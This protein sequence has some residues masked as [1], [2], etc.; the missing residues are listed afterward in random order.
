MEIFEI[1]MDWI[2]FKL[3]LRQERKRRRLRPRHVAV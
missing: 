1:V 2:E 3:A